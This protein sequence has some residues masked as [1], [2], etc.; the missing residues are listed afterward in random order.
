MNNE[1]CL[2]VLS[3]FCEWIRL[4]ICFVL[5]ILGLYE[6][7]GMCLFVLLIFFFL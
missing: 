4:L 6:L 5:F 7:N 1:M 2:F 3:F